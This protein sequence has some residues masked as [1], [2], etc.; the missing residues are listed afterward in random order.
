MV[1][2][3]RRVGGDDHSQ[4][5]DSYNNCS[6]LLS[7]AQDEVTITLI[8]T[9]DHLL[10]AFDR[11]IAEYAGKLFVREGITLKLSTR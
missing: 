9:L 1:G 6:N 11:Q 3:V 10:N 2:D 8:D 4:R 5:L 7:T